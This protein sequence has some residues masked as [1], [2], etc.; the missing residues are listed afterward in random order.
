MTNTMMTLDA[1]LQDLI[2][3]TVAAAET[4][5]GFVVAEAPIVVEQLL[6]WKF[7]AS[8]VLFVGLVLFSIGL[9]IFVRAIQDGLT[10]VELMIIIA[11]IGLLLAIGIP[12][13][14]SRGCVGPLAWLKI[15]IAPK[16]YLLEYAAHLIK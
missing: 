6:A 14:E 10:L 11:I 7:T 4:A 9:A 1:T 5:G 15:T 16:L 13:A 2:T 8:M 3:K 12:F